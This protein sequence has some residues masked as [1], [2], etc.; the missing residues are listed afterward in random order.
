MILRYL[1]S[2]VVFGVEVTGSIQGASKTNATTRKPQF[3]RNAWIFLRQILL[4]CLTHNCPG[5]CCFMPYLLDVRRNDGNFNLINEFCN[6]TIF[7]WVILDIFLPHNCDYY[8]ACLTVQRVHRQH[9]RTKHHG[10]PLS[11]AINVML[12]MSQALAARPAN[13]SNYHRQVIA[14]SLSSSPLTAYI[15][16][17]FLKTIKAKETTNMLKKYKTIRKTYSR[18]KY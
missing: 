11:L 3:L 14:N 9:V 2:I 16:F 5:V 13:N 12:L 4:V 18:P 7:N 15:S 10:V 1:R 8:T 6:W 17:H